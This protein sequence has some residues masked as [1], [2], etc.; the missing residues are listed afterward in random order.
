M[1]A[2]MLAITFFLARGTYFD[3]F[4]SRSF[5]QLKG[6]RTNERARPEPTL[7]KYA[8]RIRSHHACGVDY[9]PKGGALG[10]SLPRRPD[11][12]EGGL[13]RRDARVL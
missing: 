9:R 4:L 12:V 13:T 5:H 8:V 1:L 3:P 11:R 10:L 6:K 7:N 2:V